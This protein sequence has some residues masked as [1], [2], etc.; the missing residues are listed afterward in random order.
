MAADYV[1]DVCTAGTVVTPS[2]PEVVAVRGEVTL[3]ATNVT[4]D[5]CQMV[6]LPPGCVPVDCIL[7]AD[8]I[9]SGAASVLTVGVLN[10]AMTDL[11]T[12]MDLIYQTTIGQTGG[13]AR[14]N[15]KTLGR[16]DVDNDT[17]RYIGIKV[18]TQA[19]TRVEGV[20]GVTLLY[21]AA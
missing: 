18:A 5:T 4:G 2:G 1:S 15:I 7:D 6:P 8:D 9:D 14:G 16:V 11:E 3:P 17:L 12:D 10:T 20:L 19:G 21:H 13:I